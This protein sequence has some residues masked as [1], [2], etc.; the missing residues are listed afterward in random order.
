M[1]AKPSRKTL[2]IKLS[3]PLLSNI[4]KPR[5]SI[6]YIYNNT[7]EVHGFAIDYYDPGGVATA[8]GQQNT[9]TCAGLF[10]AETKGKER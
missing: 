2:R 3:L 5:L 10:Q 4:R 9:I 8:P 1:I 7:S 6:S